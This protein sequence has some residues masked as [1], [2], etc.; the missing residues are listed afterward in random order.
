[1]LG[2]AM[3]GGAGAPRRLEAAVDFQLRDLKGK[4]VSLSDFRGRK[5]VLLFF[6]A[7]WCPYCRTQMGKINKMYQDI[8]QRGIVVLPVNVGED[9]ARAGRFMSRFPSVPTSLLDTDRSVAQSFGVGGIP[10]YLLIDKKGNVVFL[11]NYFPD[12]EYR[13]L[14]AAT[15][16][17]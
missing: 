3:L 6:W 1:L 9:S 7:T 13:Q 17:R 16:S 15:P 2:M 14:S 12:V 10:T 4:S 8:A 11:G 5:P